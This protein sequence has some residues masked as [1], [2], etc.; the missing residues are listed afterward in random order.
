MTEQD[1]RER[2]KEFNL[3]V[4]DACTQ[5]YNRTGY[6]C[7]SKNVNTHLERY[8]KLSAWQSVAFTFFF[9]ILEGAKHEQAAAV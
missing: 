1:L 8:G 5:I 2:L 6:T 7:S 4:A 9:K 3:S